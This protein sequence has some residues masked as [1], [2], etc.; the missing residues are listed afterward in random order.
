MH[1]AWNLK[2][3]K[4]TGK[5]VCKVSIHTAALDYSEGKE[6]AGYNTRQA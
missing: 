1:R 5:E 3:L 4:R 6:P 2:R